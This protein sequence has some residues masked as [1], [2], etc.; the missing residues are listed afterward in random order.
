M[1][2]RTVRGL[3]FEAGKIVTIK[4]LNLHRYSFTLAKWL[5]IDSA[6]TSAGE[7][8]VRSSGS[9]FNL[10]LHPANE[11]LYFNEVKEVSEPRMFSERRLINSA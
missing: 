11:I 8:F 6:Y 7:S 9:A 4:N 3:W 2:L 1:R 5:W 10:D